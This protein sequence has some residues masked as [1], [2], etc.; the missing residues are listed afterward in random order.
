MDD[1]NSSDSG[2]SV[3]LNAGKLTINYGSDEPSLKY[4]IGFDLTDLAGSGVGLIMNTRG[5]SIKYLDSGFNMGADIDRLTE[6]GDFAGASIPAEML[7]NILENFPVNATSSKGNFTFTGGENDSTLRFSTYKISD[8]MSLGINLQ[9]DESRS[10]LFSFY[11]TYLSYIERT[12]NGD[13][14]EKTNMTSSQLT[15]NNTI[16]DY[17]SSEIKVG[18]LPGAPS[19]TGQIPYSSLP[20]VGEWKLSAIKMADPVVGETDIPLGTLPGIENNIYVFNDNHTFENK[21]ENNQTWRTLAQMKA[22]AANDGKDVNLITT[23]E[24][25]H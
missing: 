18:S 4:S 7:P 14:V 15:R 3:T 21:F 5:I 13:I 24:M 16:V 10:T 22:K 20:I 25:I 2:I 6:R 23:G 11:Q 8:G 9:E 19:A 17:P 12:E 1:I